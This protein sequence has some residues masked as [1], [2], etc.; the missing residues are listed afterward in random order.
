[1]ITDFLSRV[2]EGVVAPRRS[3][4]RILD[5]G[6]LPIDQ[7]ASLVVLAYALQAL[8]A[9]FFPA[10]RA[11]AES[12]I[13]WHVS[14]LISQFIGFITSS[15]I[16]FGIGRLLGGEGRIE[17]CFAGMAWCGVVTSFLFPLLAA[18]L[19]ASPDAAP[20]PGGSLL[21][22]AGV[23]IGA[24]VFAGC[25]AEIHRFKSTGAVLL[26]MFVLGTIAA[27]LTLTLIPA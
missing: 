27:L 14:A 17:D 10:F 8:F 16:V 21:L 26:A 18:G 1:M 13:A 7:I 4:R 3:V 9:V 19:P 20:S 12:L 11:G 22:L 2:A 5:Q 24:W 25:V 23:G 15:A 6:P